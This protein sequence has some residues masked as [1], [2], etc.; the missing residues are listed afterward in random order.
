MKPHNGNKRNTEATAGPSTIYTAEIVPTEDP[1]AE[2]FRAQF[3]TRSK[4][5]V[6][7]ITQI[8]GLFPDTDNCDVAAELWT[9]GSVELPGYRVRVEARL[10]SCL[11]GSVCPFCDWRERASRIR[12]RRK[13]SRVRGVLAY[14]RNSSDEK[15]R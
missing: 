6:Y 13:T 3:E 8:D 10:C 1:R 11:P 2:R 12:L 9:S 4:A 7:A 14:I 15:P 5:M